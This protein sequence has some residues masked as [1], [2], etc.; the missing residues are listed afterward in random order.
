MECCR[1]HDHKYDPISMKDYYKTF[2][3]FNNTDEA[4]LLA[5]FETS[6]PSPTLVVADANQ[7]AEL[8]KR[9]AAA[10]EALTRFTSLQQTE[11][12]RFAA[13]KKSWDG[14]VSSSGLLARYSFDELVGGKVPNTANQAKVEN[15]RNPQGGSI[16]T[17]KNLITLKHPD[18][19]THGVDTITFQLHGKERIINLSE[20]QILSGGSNIVKQ[21]TITQSSVSNPKAFTIA[22]ITDGDLNNFNHTHTEKNP[23]VKLTFPVP[24]KVDELKI[25]NRAG[26]EVEFRFNDADIR[27]ERGGKAVVT[28][29]VGTVYATG[30][31]SGANPISLSGNKHVEGLTGKAVQFDGDT[32]IVVGTI[33]PFQRHAPFSIT[34]AIDVPVRHKRAIILHRS[35][36]WTDAA[37]RGYELLIHEG[38][39]DFALVHFSPGDEIRVRTQQDIPLNAWTRIAMTYDGS[40]RAAGIRLFVNG[41]QAKTDII[42][43]H[44]TKEIRYRGKRNIEL[45]ARMRDNGFKNSKLDDLAIYDRDLTALEVRAEHNPKAKPANEAELFAYYLA[46]HADKAQAARNHLAAQRKAYNEYLD[47]RTRMMVMKE[48]AER[49]RTF[50]LKRG[51]YS[52]PDPE[53][54]VEPG[55]P[56]K[57]FPFGPEYSRDRLGFAQWLTHPE[58]PLTARV[59][60]NRYWQLLFGEGIVSTTNDFGFQGA[61]PTHP[62]LLDYLSRYFIDS[63]WDVRKL[64]KH[65]VLSHTF[66]QDSSGSAALATTDPSNKWLARGPSYHMTAEMLRDSS[67]LAG[68]GLSDQFGGSSV[69]LTSNR[70]SLYVSLK[71]NNPSPELLIFGSPRRQVC[72]VKREKTSTP[73]QPLVLLNS[74]LYVKNARLVAAASVQSATTDAERLK[75]LFLRLTSRTPAPEEQAVLLEMLTEQRAYFAKNTKVADAFLKVGG[76]AGTPKG[77]QPPEF[78]AW[79]VVAS[80]VMNLDS[81][82]MVR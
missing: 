41:E 80:A 6:V 9:K 42:R 52:E 45:A 76:G 43:D 64:F 21:A 13:W 16:E 8:A 25:W 30:T 48:L 54:E 29:N 50:V 37:S 72:S 56:E 81:F 66:R 61:L 55:P 75:H 17:Q 57:I 24:T 20:V 58:H 2:A 51:L 67:M 77:T 71:R 46:Q 70:R 15:A 32:K 10:A 4:G 23:W 78:A 1:C 59:T 82:Y 68:N 39:L 38:K 63:G 35:Q 27:Y 18:V 7:K 33:G 69:G 62:E 11:Q 22:H 49:R 53:Q 14:T 31:S 73:L 74:P 47:G 26:P 12:A 5:F 40:G 19:A 34:A 3:L 65:I 44:L 79:S 60:V 28:Q 36:A